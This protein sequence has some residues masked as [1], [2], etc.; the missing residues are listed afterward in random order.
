MYKRQ[1]LASVAVENESMSTYT[2]RIRNRAIYTNNIEVGL[3]RKE[4]AEYIGTH[5]NNGMTCGDVINKRKTID[6]PIK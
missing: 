1:A 2:L 3:S 4:E 5:S 6:L